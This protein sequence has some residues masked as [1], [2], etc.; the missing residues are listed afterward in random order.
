MDTSEITLPFTDAVTGDPLPLSAEAKL[1]ANAAEVLPE[2]ESTEALN[3]FTVIVNWPESGTVVQ[4]VP[5]P[6]SVTHET[7]EPSVPEIVT[8]PVAW[9]PFGAVSTADV[10][11]FN[12]SYVKTR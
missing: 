7:V 1:L 4:C 6:G 3:P 10:R 2:P 12:L 5:W 9:V 11:R 8:D